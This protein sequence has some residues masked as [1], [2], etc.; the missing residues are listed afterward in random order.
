MSLN[1]KIQIT[2]FFLVFAGL[3]TLSCNIPINISTFVRSKSDL[4]QHTTVAEF[5]AT[6]VSSEGDAILLPLIHRQEWSCEDVNGELSSLLRSEETKVNGIQIHKYK[7]ALLEWEFIYSDTDGWIWVSYQK[8]ID[9]DYAVIGAENNV[10]SWENDKWSG[11]TGKGGFKLGKNLTF[12]GVLEVKIT[13]QDSFPEPNTSERMETHNIFGLIA[14]D[15]SQQAF[16]CDYVV[17]PLPEGIDL[18][19]PEKFQ[20][21]CQFYYYECSLK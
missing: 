3:V 14:E 11:K 6:L 13:Q 10:D 2:L 12:Q 5:D 18:L 16:L 15:N 8:D 21:H 4:I 7:K 20:D 1:K 9:R 19:T 17:N